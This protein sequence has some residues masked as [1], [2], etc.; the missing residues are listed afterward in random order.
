MSE[1]QSARDEPLHR[2]RT[3]LLVLCKQTYCEAKPFLDQLETPSLYITGSEC[4]LF[5][6]RREPTRYQSISIT[7]PEDTN[8]SSNAV[9]RAR[10]HY[11]LS[12]L[13]FLSLKKATIRIRMKGEVEC[14]AAICKINQLNALLRTGHFWQ[15]L[16]LELDIKVCDP[17]HKLTLYISNSTGGINGTYDE[18]KAESEVVTSLEQLLLGLESD[19]CWLDF[20]WHEDNLVP[21][22]A[23]LRFG[24]QDTPRFQAARKA[25]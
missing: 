21:A 19:S 15:D 6:D 16:R 5:R 4:S 7:A 25:G 13:E 23:W 22:Y 8:M 17:D 1:S 9:D 3:T 12:E 18:P 24:F 14:A 10:H 2:G 20:E 11:W